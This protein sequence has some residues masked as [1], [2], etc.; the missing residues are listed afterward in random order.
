MFGSRSCFVSSRTKCSWRASRYSRTVLL[1][2]TFRK[3][4]S[5][6]NKRPRCPLLLVV[7]ISTRPWPRREQNLLSPIV[8]SPTHARPD[9]PTFSSGRAARSE[10]ESTPSHPSFPASSIVLLRLTPP[11]FH[12]PLRTS[13]WVG[14]RR[15]SSNDQHGCPRLSRRVCAR[16]AVSV[17]CTGMQELEDDLGTTLNEDKPRFP[18]WSTALSAA[19]RETAR[20]YA[21]HWHGSESWDLC[22]LP[23]RMDVAGVGLRAA[24][25]LR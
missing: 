11:C 23:G 21:T 24:R 3:R 2:A 8:R 10:E 17:L 12:V 14:V 6:T 5:S 4:L 16:E 19:C 22:S 7:G 1:L 20:R 9:N 18:S 15:K 25:L 13:R